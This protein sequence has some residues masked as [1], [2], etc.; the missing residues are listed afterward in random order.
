MGRLPSNPA[1]Q[2]PFNAT[3]RTTWQQNNIVQPPSQPRYSYRVKIINPIRK[4]D[5]VVRELRH[6]H[7]QFSSIID[8]KVRL[9]EELEES[10]PQT[11]KF[12]IGYFVQSTKYWI[13]NEEDLKALYTTSD[14]QITLWCDGRE[15]NCTESTPSRSSKRRKKSDEHATKREEKEQHVEDLAKELQELHGDKLELSDT[16]YRLWARMIITGIH[17]SKET[18]P[19]IP[20][21]TGVTPKRKQSDTFKDT[22]MHTATAVMKAVTSNFPSPTIVQTPQI[23]QTIS[24]SQEAAGVSPGKAADIRGKSFDQLST[25]KKLFEDGVLTQKEFEEQKDIILTGLKR[26]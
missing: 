5:V 14:N 2:L 16:Q 15:E 21:I 19:Q 1:L 7:G 17:A 22:I 8:L 25:L 12:A 26:L 13:Y 24:Q 23:Q 6:F 4:K 18:P 9:M 3:Q 10:V 11:T 20:L